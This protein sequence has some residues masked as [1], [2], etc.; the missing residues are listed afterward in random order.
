ME[1]KTAEAFILKNL[2]EGQLEKT[3]VYV[4]R[5]CQKAMKEY[6]EQEIK[7]H[8]EIVSNEAK[9]KLKKGR[10]MGFVQV[11]DKESITSIEIKLS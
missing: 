1:L 10:S 8:L 3:P 4:L 6:A 5:N 7:K 11:V 2:T 9:L